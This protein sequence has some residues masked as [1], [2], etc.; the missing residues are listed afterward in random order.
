M[1]RTTS[2]NHWCSNKNQEDVLEFALLAFLQN[3]Q[4]VIFRGTVGIAFRWYPSLSGLGS[5]EVFG[6]GQHPSLWRPPGF[7]GHTAVGLFTPGG[8]P[9]VR[10]GETATVNHQRK[11]SGFFMFCRLQ[12]ISGPSKPP[13]IWQSSTWIWPMSLEMC[14]SL[15]PPNPWWRWVWSP[16][17]SQDWASRGHRKVTPITRTFRG[18]RWIARAEKLAPD[19]YKMNKPGSQNMHYYDSILSI[20]AHT[21]T[22]ADQS[23]WQLCA[24]MLQVVQ[25]R[26]FFCST[27]VVSLTFA[28]QRARRSASFRKHQS[29]GLFRPGFHQ[30]HWRYPGLEFHGPIA[31]GPST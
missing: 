11:T 2:Y 24:N 6:P 14:K 13:R 23:S 21:C 26:S 27:I 29:V 15:G 17:M 3:N 7:S 5:V 28:W 12:V 25:L 16:P 31:G 18:R 19:S 8:H 1:I 30:G 10:P 20:Y 4:A 22:H 9:S